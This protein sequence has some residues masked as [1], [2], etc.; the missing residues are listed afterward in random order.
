M[1]V[2]HGNKVVHVCEK[3]AENKCILLLEQLLLGCVLF[4]IEM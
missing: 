1:I 3:F 2:K 4:E